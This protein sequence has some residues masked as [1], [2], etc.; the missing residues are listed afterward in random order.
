MDNT[1]ATPAE[2]DRARGE[3]ADDDVAIDD[4]A[5]CSRESKGVWIQAWVYLPYEQGNP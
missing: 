5:L 1:H 2:I 4:D 3:Y